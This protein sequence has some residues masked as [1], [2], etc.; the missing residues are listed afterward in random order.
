MLPLSTFFGQT[1][2]AFLPKD[3]CSYF[4]GLSHSEATKSVQ[5]VQ[6]SKW[7]DTLCFVVVVELEIVF[8]SSLSQL[9]VLSRL[10][11]NWGNGSEMAPLVRA[12]ALRVAPCMDI[13]EGL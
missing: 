5:L 11:P 4:C 8:L 9:R 13:A 6:A 2:T 12:K 3:L 10:I 1:L 7:L